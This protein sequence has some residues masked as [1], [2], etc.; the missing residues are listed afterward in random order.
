MRSITAKRRTFGISAM[1]ILSLAACSL[2]GCGLAGCSS[3]DT[4][5]DSSSTDDELRSA[6]NVGVTAAAT[7]TTATAGDRVDIKLTVTTH[8]TV[9]ADIHLTIY[10]P[11]G[12]SAYTA[13]WPA[14]Q[15]TPGTPLVLTE[16]ITVET[17]DPAG[18]YK[19]G[20]AVTR[21]GGSGLFSNKSIA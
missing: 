9:T 16:A 12:S 4:P 5:S 10:A 3:A 1:L 8:R 18:A 7:P 6:A 21:T 17:T 15:L 19:V 11:N 20:A 14:Q 2:A 13:S